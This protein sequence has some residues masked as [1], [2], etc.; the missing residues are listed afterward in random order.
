MK[1]LY[2]NYKS[3]LNLAIKKMIVFFDLF[4]YPLSAFEIYIKLEKKYSL[5]N[6]FSELDS[7]SLFIN[8]KNGFYFLNGREKLVELR[9]KRYNYSVR[10][11]KV[12]K[13]YAKI[14]SLL[15]YVKVVTLANVI[16]SHNMRDEG[17]I[18][19]FII[20][21]SGRLWLS[22]L[23]CAGLAKSL[24][25]RP[26]KILKK[27]KLCLSFY[28]GDD[29][30]NL[31]NLK[32][33]PEDPYFDY[34]LK[35]MILLYNKKEV[36]E[37]FLSANNLL[38]NNESRKI[39]LIRKNNNFLNNLEKIAKYIQLKIMPE[40]LRLVLKSSNGEFINDKIL[41]L[42]WRDRNAEILEKL[43]YVLNQIA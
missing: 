7:L 14:F 32:I 16:G 26:T 21:S 15:P 38:E 22:R 27:D 2:I 37:D 11:I 23:F 42:Y 4:D 29:N 9:Q 30:L 1:D 3:N 20:T 19:F 8:K 34:W 12:A 36:Y 41:K 25:K 17:D 6:V 28:I 40:E 24:N 33:K 5:S 13:R 18:D 43:N 35:T 39:T 31:D 10:K